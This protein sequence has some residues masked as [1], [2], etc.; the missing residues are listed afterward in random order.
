MMDGVSPNN[1]CFDIEELAMQVKATK[2]SI[3]RRLL[4][5]GMEE[6]IDYV[7]D[8]GK[9]REGPLGEPRGGHNRETILLTKSCYDQLLLS[10]KLTKR[11]RLPNDMKVEYVKRYLPKETET[12]TFIYEAFKGVYNI[13]LQH[14]VL[15]YRVDMYIVDKNIVVECDEHGHANRDPTYEI[16]RQE[17]IAECYNCKFIRFNPDAPD[18]QLSK[19]I[20]TIIKACNT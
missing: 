3:K 10:L 14:Q 5:S 6:N 8:V 15:R 11:S 1:F 9:R 16:T 18:F 12:L 17:D 19:L 2:G 4:S 7:V 20:N 13:V